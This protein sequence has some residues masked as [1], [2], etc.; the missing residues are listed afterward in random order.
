M[1]CYINIIVKLKFINAFL[2]FIVILYLKKYLYLYIY[3][4]FI[5]HIYINLIFLSKFS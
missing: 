1:N 2:V 5:F 3:K 4:I